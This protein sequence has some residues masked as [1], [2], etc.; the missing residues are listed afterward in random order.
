LL[1][2]RATRDELSARARAYVERHC[3]FRKVAAVFEDICTQ[4]AAARVS[5][6]RCTA[7]MSDLSRQK[8]ARKTSGR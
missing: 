1:H 2:N 7:T 8:P 3:S 5:G 4:A 6:P